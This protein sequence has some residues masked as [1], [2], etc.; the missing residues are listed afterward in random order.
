LKIS[1]AAETGYQH[2]SVF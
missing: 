1:K 2:K